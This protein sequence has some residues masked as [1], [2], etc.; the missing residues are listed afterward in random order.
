MIHYYHIMEAVDTMN[1][2]RASTIVKGRPEIC[3]DC[4]TKFVMENFHD[5]GTEKQ[6][7]V[8][9]SFTLGVLAERLS[10][11]SHHANMN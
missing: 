6:A 3:R 10:N 4:L 1:H 7:L 8:D 11:Q 5:H 9:L 2:G